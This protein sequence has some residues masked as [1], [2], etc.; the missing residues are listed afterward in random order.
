MTVLAKQAMRETL[1]VSHTLP[2]SFID[3]FVCYIG[4]SDHTVGCGL[5]KASSS[6]SQGSCIPDGGEG[7]TSKSTRARDLPVKAWHR[8]GVQN[9]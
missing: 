4:I 7:E 6:H 9:G 1:K 5:P 2:L 3:I 8:R